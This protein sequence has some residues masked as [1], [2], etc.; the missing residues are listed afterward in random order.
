MCGTN[1]VETIA[2]VATGGLALP[3]IM[4]RKAMKE[5]QASQDKAIANQKAKDDAAA[6][7]AAALGPAAKSIDISDEV[8][9]K[10]A[11]RRSRA[12]LQTGIMGT[13]KTGP[14]GAASAT[15]LK[16]TLGS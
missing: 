8:G 10:S 16:T 15:T 7:E 2:T 12:A 13:L 4:Q 14:M 3:L 11:A 1:P 6:A 5:Q 9:A